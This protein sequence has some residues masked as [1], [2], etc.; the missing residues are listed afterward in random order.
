MPRSKSNSSLAT[1]REPFGKVTELM[2]VPIALYEILALAGEIDHPK[3]GQIARLVENV[4]EVTFDDPEAL[5][6]LNELQF[7][8]G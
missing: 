3:A 5:I 7:T 6:K 4:I 1:C 8:N 2:Q